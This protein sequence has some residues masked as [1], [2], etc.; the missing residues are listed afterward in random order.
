[1]LLWADV[2][3]LGILA[4]GA[5]AIN[6]MNQVGG[7]VGPYL[8]GLAKDATGTYSL[9]LTVMTG[10]MLLAAALVMIL[11]ADVARQRATVRAVAVRKSVWRG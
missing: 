6:S 1:V 7:F 3:P 2:L 8:W 5:A 4:V 9:A 11:R 10:A